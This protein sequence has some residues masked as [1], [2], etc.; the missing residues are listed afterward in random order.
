MG[1]YQRPGIL[2]FWRE[3]FAGMARVHLLPKGQVIANLTLYPVRKHFYP[4]GSDLL[5]GNNVSIHRP[6]GIT[7]W[8]TS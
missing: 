2:S 5:Q 3:R 1:A 7:Q 6:Q 4:D 8:F